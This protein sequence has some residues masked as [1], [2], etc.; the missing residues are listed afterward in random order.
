MALCEWAPH[1]LEKPAVFLWDFARM[2]TKG[3]LY[4]DAGELALAIRNMGLDAR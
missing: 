3:G 4:A 1:F 2:A